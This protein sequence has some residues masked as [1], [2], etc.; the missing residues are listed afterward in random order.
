[1]QSAASGGSINNCY[2]PRDVINPNDTTSLQIIDVNYSSNYV[3]IQLFSERA[4]VV[5]YQFKMSGIVISDVVALTNSEDMPIHLGFNTYRNE[6]FGIYHAD[7]VI[8]HS[9]SPVALCRIYFTELNGDPICISQIVDIPNS[10]GERTVNEVWGDCFVPEPTSIGEIPQR[11]HL[12]ILPNPATDMAWVNVPEAFSGKGTWQ[13]FDATG[14]FVNTLAP[15]VSSVSRQ[16]NVSLSGIAD[17]VYIL[18]V[19]DQAGQVSVGRLVKQ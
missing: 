10:L 17:G 5:A 7:S 9:T 2:F 16:F 15:Q 18:R 13:L 1:L 4:N 6:V 14:R 3:D 11:A 12:T 19:V 8:A